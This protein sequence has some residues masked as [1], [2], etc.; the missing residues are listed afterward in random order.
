M[1]FLTPHLPFHDPDSERA[2]GIPHPGALPP[3]GSHLVITDTIPSPGHFAVY[4]LVSAALARKR[5]VVWV[6]FRG[7][8]R[9]SWE[10][11]LKKLGTPLPAPS[12]GSFIHLTPTSLPDPASSPSTSTS[13]PPLFDETTD[14][15]VLKPTYEALL[16]HIGASAS[17]S[18]S[19]S[20]TKSEPQSESPQGAVD[21]GAVVILDGLAELLWMGFRPVDVGR[22]VRSVFAKVRS[23]RGTLISTLHADHLPLTSSLPSGY[24][25]YSGSTV[26][27]S[28]SGFGFGVGS[29]SSAAEAEL[30]ERL[31]RMGGGGWWRVSHLASG[32]SGDVSGEISAASNFPP[33]GTAF[34]SVPRSKPLQYRLETNTV[35]V[36]PKG[37]G[38]GFL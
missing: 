30:L 23:T 28:V 14:A 10:T 6:D 26:S 12:S 3:P 16:P 24:S 21:T 18:A 22:F 7:E 15:P 19:A 20:G 35:K 9:S 1:T 11:V 25:G 34:P 38:R 36:F 33:E 17:A 2:N 29:D 32:R 4:H 13:S 5:K 37:T 8:G 27:A 31:L